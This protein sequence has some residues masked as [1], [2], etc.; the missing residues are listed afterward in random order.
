MHLAAWLGPDARQDD[1]EITRHARAAGVGLYA[2]SRF[3]LDPG[4]RPGLVIGYGAIARDRI[5][6]SLA[7]LSTVITRRRPAAV[8]ARRP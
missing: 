6:E 5:E 1:R 3:A 4:Q 8:S 7:R 2:I